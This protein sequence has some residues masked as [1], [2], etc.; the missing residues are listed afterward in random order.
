VELQIDAFLD[1]RRKCT[2][3]AHRVKLTN[4]LGKLWNLVYAKAGVRRLREESS[5]PLF[6]GPIE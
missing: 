6:L 1:E 4:S 3:P 5:R 2:D